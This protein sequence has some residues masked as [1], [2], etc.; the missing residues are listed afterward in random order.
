MIVHFLPLLESPVRNPLSHD[1]CV[2]AKWVKFLTHLHFRRVTNCTK[3]TTFRKLKSQ[4]R[5]RKGIKKGY[6]LQ[7]VRNMSKLWSWIYCLIRCPHPQRWRSWFI[8]THVSVHMICPCMMVLKPNFQVL[9]AL[10]ISISFL[11]Q[12]HPH[13]CAERSSCTVYNQQYWYVLSFIW[14]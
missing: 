10:H 14:C 3:S 13:R 8:E 7:L 6:W 12:F 4:K 11:W 9:R 1:H 5:S 2:G